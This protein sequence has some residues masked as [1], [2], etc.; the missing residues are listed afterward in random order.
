MLKLGRDLPRLVLKFTFPRREREGGSEGA[1][2]EEE[3][4]SA[5]FHGDFYRCTVLPFL[6][7]TAIVGVLIKLVAHPLR[8]H[9]ICYS[10]G[11]GR[12][13]EREREAHA[14]RP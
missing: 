1:R 9:R 12:E 10:K 6:S 4:D 11:E 3:E 8:E 7:L 2:E 13:R 14:T 5:D